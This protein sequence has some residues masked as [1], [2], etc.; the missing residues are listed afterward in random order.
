MDVEDIR[1]IR[2]REKDQDLEELYVSS[3]CSVIKDYKHFAVVRL[4]TFSTRYLVGKAVEGVTG[5]EHFLT[6]DV[7]EYPGFTQKPVSIVFTQQ[8]HNGIA[9]SITKG[10][11]FINEKVVKLDYAF[12]DMRPIVQRNVVNEPIPQRPESKFQKAICF[13]QEKMQK[14]EYCLIDG[15]VYKKLGEAKYTYLEIGN[16]FC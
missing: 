12:R 4:A 2:P 16:Y 6:P 7:P 9:A 15:G 14:N 11:E 8:I 13:V 5:Q 3:L 10:L 1:E